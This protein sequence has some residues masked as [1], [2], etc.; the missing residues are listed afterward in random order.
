MKKLI[1]LVLVL[2]FCLSLCACGGSSGSNSK[3][4][5][6]V[7]ICQLVQHPALDSATKGFRDALEAAMPGQIVFDEKNA[8][9]DTATCATIVNGFVASNVDLILANATP[10]LQAA[11]SATQS[12]PVLGTSITE[13]GVALDI[14]N[15]NGTVGG[16]V[17]GT[18]DLAPLE[19]QAAMFDELIPQASKIGI[20]YC[21]A[22]ANSVYQAKVVKAALESAGKTVTVYTFADSNDVSTVTAQACSENDALYIPTDNTAA[23]SAEAINNVAEPAGIPI[24]CGEESLCAACGIAA[25]SIDYYELGRTTGEMAARIL[26]GESKIAEMPVEYFQNPVKKFNASLCNELGITVPDGYEAME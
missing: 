16:N 25:L 18:S 7:G 17:S 3:K 20:L 21:S 23:T 9:G 10:A 22:E 2:A 19:Q 14:Q 8:S 4:T 13:Y 24:I 11:T 26:K 6:T 15:F 12:I 1:S 5:F